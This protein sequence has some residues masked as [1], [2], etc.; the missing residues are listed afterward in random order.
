M[1]AKICLITFLL[2]AFQLCGAGAP[3][4]SETARANLSEQLG[5]FYAFK[6]G[7]TPAQKKIDTQILMRSSAITSPQVTVGL[8]NGLVNSYAGEN[9]YADCNVKCTVSDRLVELIKAKG[10]IV[11]SVS[12]RFGAIHAK[13]PFAAIE[14][15]AAD[16]DVKSIKKI[17]RGM[18]NKGTTSE[19]VK[20]HRADTARSSYGVT[21]AGVKVGVISDGC[22]DLRTLQYSGDLPSNVQVL[23]GRA[24]SG[25]EGGAMMEIVHDMAPNAGLAF[26]NYG[27]SCEEFGEAILAL[28][29]AGC[30]VVVDDISFGNDAAFEDGPISQAINEMTKKGGVYVTCACN[31]GAYDRG[32]SCVWEGDFSASDTSPYFKG[33]AGFEKYTKSYV[34]HTF[35]ADPIVKQMGY[36]CFNEI[37]GVNGSSSGS[38]YLCLQWADKWG[39]SANDYDFFVVDLYTGSLIVASA[40]D[41]NGNDDPIEMAEFPNTALYM[42]KPVVMVVKKTT[43]KARFFRFEIPRGRLSLY[44]SGSIFGHHANENAITCA[45]AAAPSGRVFTANDPLEDFSSDGPGFRFYKTNGTAYKTG[46][47][48]LFDGGKGGGVEIKKPDVTAADSVSCSANGFENFPG[49]SAAA[50]HGAAI[51]ALMLEANPSLSAAKVKELMTKSTMRSSVTWDRNYGYGI[52]DAAKCVQAARNEPQ[53]T[54]S[55]TYKPGANGT[56]SEVTD[57][58]T[59]GKAL[60]LRGATF[61][62]TGYVQTGWSKTDG[63]AQAYALGASYTT[64]A[65]LTLYPVW[66][67]EPKSDLAFLTRSQIEG[68][69]YEGWEKTMFLSADLPTSFAYD[70][71]SEYEVGATPCI[72]FL[73]GNLGDADASTVKI[74]FEILDSD[75]QV[76]NQLNRSSEILVES[77]CFVALHYQWDVMSSL[78]AGK[79][80]LRMTLDSDGTSDSSSAANKVATYDFTVKAKSAPYSIRFIRN[81]GSGAMETKSFPYG[82]TTALPTLDSLGWARRGYTFM[83]WYTSTANIAAGKNPWKT[84]GGTVASPTAAGKQMDAYARWELKTGYYQ[85]KF[86]KND[87][88]DKWRTLAYEHGKSTALPT[89][90]A[91]LGWTRAGYKFEGWAVSAANARA[92]KVWKAGGAKVST[93]TDKGSTLSVYAV[94]K[95]LPKYRI[96][97]IRNDGAGTTVT[98]DFPCTQ[99]TALPTLS[100]LG[101]ARRGY[102]FTG[103][104]TSTKNIAADNSPWKAD[105]AKVTDAIAEGRTLDVYAGWKLKSGYYQIKFYKNDGT[106]KWR[107]LGYEY[108]K[109]TALPSCDAGLGWTRAGHVFGGWAT[110]A[111]NAKAGKVWKDDAAKVATTVAPGQSFSCYAI[112]LPA[113]SIRFIRNDGAGTMETRSFPYG[114]TTALPKL[115]AMDWARRGYAFMGWYTSTAN[116]AAGKDPWKTDGGTV[117]SPIAAGTTMDVYAGWK[118]K[119]GCYQIKFN[120]N[121]GTGKWRTLAYEY[122]KSTALPT[123]VKGLGWTRKGYAFGGWATSA[124]NARA[125]KVWKPDAAKVATTVAAGQSFSCYAI[126]KKTSANAVSL[127]GAAIPSPASDPPSLIPGHYSGLFADGSGAFDLLVEEDGSAFF[128][129]ETED[130]VWEAECEAEPVDGTLVLIFADGSALVIRMED[131]TAMA[132]GTMTIAA[133]WK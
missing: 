107:T 87:G 21:G 72:R 100:A 42:H 108:G 92:G 30:K 55:V 52:L 57:K 125:G 94:W 23:S 31:S 99:T 76:K 54:Y 4:M 105:G 119:G 45:A 96:R 20:A 89:C 80:R 123:C 131:G 98:K 37:T 118:L 27:S 13:I 26:A 111:A 128:R 64:D 56:G 106:D 48:G 3:E 101:W 25:Y 33:K 69:N 78:A 68:T 122:G 46:T 74:T 79:Y 19:G 9:G 8:P 120:K 14:Q 127:C 85:I 95:E 60:T 38:S 32:T 70:P 81:D 10:G 104:Y 97:F 129:A 59:K 114:V 66:T 109:S 41:Q 47:A 113:Y 28:F 115:N 12:Q 67:A 84:D 29:N 58:K 44:S 18:T 16:S 17:W 93:A 50:P 86:Y 62:R 15:I 77:M 130:G 90:E 110:S 53:I 124:A 11:I 39:K 132:I 49:T 133:A 6:E 121:D 83:G 24:G 82:V 40:D 34:C 7:R 91:G 117:A 36:D 102:T 22:D 1:G 126:W 103:W 63:G 51:A 71:I 2:A 116:I 5:R 35:T 112:W 75:G 65:A 73:V 88:T 43:A 61:T